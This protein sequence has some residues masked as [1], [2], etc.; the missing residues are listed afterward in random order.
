[1]AAAAAKKGNERALTADNDDSG[2]GLR[3]EAIYCLKKIE[4][5]IYLA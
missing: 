2:F 5:L 3:G 1:M 4:F